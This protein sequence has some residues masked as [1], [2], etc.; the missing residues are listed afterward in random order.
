MVH[1]EYS[2]PY[3]NIVISEVAIHFR[4][5]PYSLD[6]CVC[7]IETNNCFFYQL[8]GKFA[9]RRGPHREH[10][11]GDSRKIY[12]SAI[13]DGGPANLLHCSILELGLEIHAIPDVLFPT[14]SHTHTHTLPFTQKKLSSAT[15]RIRPH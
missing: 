2:F 6:F 3:V 8:E 10:A 5:F 4:L 12:S 14:P 15:Q 13:Q 7:A 11:P 9:L 1:L